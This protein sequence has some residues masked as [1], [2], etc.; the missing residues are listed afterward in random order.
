MPGVSV[1]VS[2]AALLARSALGVPVEYM[3]GSGYRLTG[4]NGR[5]GSGNTASSCVQRS[6]ESNGHVSFELFTRYVADVGIAAAARGRWGFLDYEMSS[7][8]ETV[9]KKHTYELFGAIELLRRLLW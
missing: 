6:K 4:R 5:I 1:F 2:A 7:T 8:Q 3:R 9:H